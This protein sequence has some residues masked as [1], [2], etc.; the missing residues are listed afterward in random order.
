MAKDRY[1]AL[2][3]REN[4]VVGPR[5]LGTDPEE[6]DS[7]GRYDSLGSTIYLAD[8]RGCAYA[9]VLGGFRKDYAAVAKVA[10]SIGWDPNEYIAA[11]L[12]D[13]HNN[14]VDPPWAISLDW[15]MDRSIYDIRLPRE[16]WWVQIDHPDTF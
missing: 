4:A 1:G 9:E 7:R 11:V 8:S 5:P 6:S 13:A 3:V 14:D 16:G 15:Q 10:E 12:D 2:A